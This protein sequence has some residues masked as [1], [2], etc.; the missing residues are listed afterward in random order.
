MLKPIQLQKTE[1]HDHMDRRIYLDRYKNIYV[2]T[3]LDDDHPEICATCKN[4]EPEYP[5]HFQI[6]KKFTD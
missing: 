6:V 4:G 5:V 1:R 3:N 2:D